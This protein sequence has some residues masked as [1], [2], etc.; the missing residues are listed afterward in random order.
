[1]RDDTGMQ[2]EFAYSEDHL[3]DLLENCATWLQKSER[4]E[5]LGEIYRFILPIYEQKR[6]FQRLSKAYGLLHEAY[7]KIVEVMRSGKRL[8][9][10]YFRVAFFGQ[11]FF[12][13]EDGKEYVYKEP[14]IT[15]LTE[16]CDRLLKLYSDKF[17]QGNVKL[18]M[19]SNKVNPK[20][21]DPKTAY[22][23][24]TYVTPYFDEKELGERQTQF[25][26]SNN[27]RCFMFETPFTNDGKAHGLIE[28]QQKRRTILTTS[29]SFP[30]V[31]KRIQV[32]YRNDQVLSPIEVAIDEMKNKV[33]ELNEVVEQQDHDLKKLQLK[34]QGSISVQVNA[35]PV[36]YA[37]AFLTDGKIQKYKRDKVG[38]LKEYFRSFVQI[39]KEGLELNGSLIHDDQREYHESLRKNFHEMSQR[40]GEI[41]GESL[42][43][44][45]DRCSVASNRNSA[46]LQGSISTTS[47]VMTF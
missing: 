15:G 22:I 42:L 40:L 16:I 44:E 23:Q 1:M 8:L 45:D 9:G 41:F 34:L 13:E 33:A 5:L 39:C 43:E 31:K 19:D 25:E 11:S 24:V 18:I 6:D 21:L 10:K 27:I 20:D 38:T 2:L 46:F 47:S 17:G 28:E 30:Y 35:G 12:E 3:T 26:R 36:A 7:S 14:K 4:Y 32:V 37:E 29:H